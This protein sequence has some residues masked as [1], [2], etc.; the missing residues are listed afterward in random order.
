VRK[1]AILLALLLL[2]S[3]ALVAFPNVGIVKAEENTIYIRA[4]GTVEETDKIQRNGNLY[5]FTGDISNRKILVEKDD[6]VIDGAG[7]TLIG[8]EGRGIVLSERNNVTVKNVKLEME[9]GYG[10]LLSTASNCTISGNTIIGDAYNINLDNSFNN[11]VE[12]NTVTNASRGILIYHSNNNKIIGNIVTDSRVG[13]ELHDCYGNVLR[14]NQMR[15]NRSNFSV[16]QYPTYSYD[17]DVDASNTVDGKPIIYWV[18]QQDKTVP[19]NA[20]YVALINCTNIKVQNLNQL[21]I[22]LVHTKDSTIKNNIQIN[23]MLIHSSNNSI[24]ENKVQNGSTGIQLEESSSNTISRNYI[25]YNDRGIRPLYSSANNSISEN[26]ITENEYG[27]DD[28]QDPT[29]SNQILRNNITANKFGID[30]LSSSNIISENTITGNEL[31]ILSSGSNRLIG[32]KVMNNGDGIYLRSS[33]N[34]LRD[35][36]MENNSRNFTPSS[37]FVN[38]V[39]TSNTVENK[40]IVYWVNQEDK[41]VPSDAGYVALVNCKNITVKNLTLS[42]NVEG[43][44]LAFTTDSMITQNILKNM[45]Y[46]IRIYGSSNNQIIAN[47]ITNNRYGILFSGYRFLGTYDPSPNNI[48]Y[49][50]NF[51]D[52]QEAVHDIAESSS[53]WFEAD[54]AVNI[55]DNGLEGNYW[56]SYNGTDNDGDSIG[57]TPYIIDEYNQDN[58]PLMEPVIIPEFHYWTPLPIA[59]VAVVAVAVV[60]RRSL[61]KRAQRRNEQ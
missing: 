18:N 25:A 36:H 5:T 24:T 33:N 39:D 11:T 28:L 61:L 34:I 51:V 40:P 26:E 58:Y 35:N 56:S 49:H 38:D 16:R 50:N 31:G 41:T 44:F 19:S 46:G 60:Y 2:V 42:Y 17:N 48:I 32:N 22:L 10:I 9:G 53:I 13:I 20:A 30:L 59:L 15:N 37:G 52:N 43:I 1:S 6:I 12:G 29:G 57:D 45:S 4:D 3:L 27:I 54:P 23:I 47:N 14:N 7:Y 8:T 21:G 55:W